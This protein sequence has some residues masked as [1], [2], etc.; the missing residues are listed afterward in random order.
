MN[1]I[2]WKRRTNTSDSVTGVDG[3]VQYRTRSAREI[4]TIRTDVALNL[5]KTGTR[6]AR[7]DFT[8]LA[9]PGSR[10]GTFSI[11]YFRYLKVSY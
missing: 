2:F 9:G 3:A 10:A 11:F 7:T 6:I 1:F 5:L 8:L 4:Q